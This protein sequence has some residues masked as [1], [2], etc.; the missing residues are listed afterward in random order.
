MLSVVLPRSFFGL[1]PSVGLGLRDAPPARAPLLLDA[2]HADCHSP[3]L[4]RCDPDRRA[5]L[6]RIHPATNRRVNGNLT[7]PP[8][9]CRCVRGSTRV[10]KGPRQRVRSLEM[11]DRKLANRR[12]DVVA[13]VADFQ[14]VP[15]PRNTIMNAMMNDDNVYGF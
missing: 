4:V 2:V 1:L 5:L 12:R 10:Q 13:A 6:R 15:A 7:Q 14:G 3:L 11:A 8:S 9:A